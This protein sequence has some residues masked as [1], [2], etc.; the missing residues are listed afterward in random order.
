MA[1]V[2]DGIKSKK[3]EGRPIDKSVTDSSLST[4]ASTSHLHDDALADEA[5]VTIDTTHSSNATASTS[6]WHSAISDHK[7]TDTTNELSSDKAD[8]VI[9]FN[10]SSSSLTAS[11]TAPAAEI[12]ENEGI[13]GV[14]HRPRGSTDASEVDLPDILTL[15]NLSSPESANASLSPSAFFDGD[16]EEGDAGKTASSKT[17]KKTTTTVTTASKKTS[18]VSLVSVTSSDSGIHKSPPHDVQEAPAEVEKTEKTTSIEV[19][20]SSTQS[21]AKKIS[22]VRMRRDDRKTSVDKPPKGD[23]PRPASCN[24]SST[25]SSSSFDLRMHSVSDAAA[26]TIPLH[27]QWYVTRR[28]WALLVEQPYFHCL[29][30]L[31]MGSLSCWFRQNYL[32]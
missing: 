20:A 8:N 31:R 7:E 27:Q 25:S 2:K 22:I 3:T 14:E 13:E 24:F 17:M 16:T 15:N 21:T 29:V 26:R 28:D 4:L 19:A 23:K 11:S 12:G 9:R 5:D 32:F 10:A 30:Q 6:S 18:A 1:A